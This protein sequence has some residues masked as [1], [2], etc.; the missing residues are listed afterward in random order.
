MPSVDVAFLEVGRAFSD[1]RSDWER[2]IYVFREDFCKQLGSPTLHSV[3]E[4]VDERTYPENR[5]MEFPQRFRVTGSVTRRESRARETH[6]AILQCQYG[7]A[8]G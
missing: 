6:E 3:R 1:C 2:V 5:T 8:W 7:I 4:R